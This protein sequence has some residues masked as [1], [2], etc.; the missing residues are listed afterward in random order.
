MIDKFK[1]LMSQPGPR[2]VIVGG[3]VFVFELA[4]IKIALMMGANNLV[5]VGISFWLG[6]IASFLLQKFFA[7]GDKRTQRHVVL[8]QII[9]M[10]LLVLFNFGFTLVVTDLLA[11]HI[12]TF[13][14]RA[15]AV[16]ITT[17]WNFYLYRTRI[18]NQPQGKDVELIG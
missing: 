8:P 18:F 11:D 2:Y 9:A 13:L 5:A 12:S 4:V 3:S 6:F 16:G 14:S 7:F 1:Q 15:L 17:I 10:A